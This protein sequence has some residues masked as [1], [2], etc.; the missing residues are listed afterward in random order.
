MLLVENVC[1]PICRI[2][3]DYMMN[4]YGSYFSVIPSYKHTNNL[5]YTLHKPPHLELRLVY[6]KDVFC[7]SSYFL[8][9]QLLMVNFW[10]LVLSLFSQ[11]TQIYVISVPR[12]YMSHLSMLKMPY[13]YDTINN[14]LHLK[15][16]K[17]ISKYV[18]LTS[19]T[20]NCHVF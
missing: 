19:V 18:C 7:S 16:R 1:C 2:A 15:L 20:Q 5:N 17:T 12:F 3:V 9:I 6:V 4:N 8:P 11:N 13:K 14:K 10:L